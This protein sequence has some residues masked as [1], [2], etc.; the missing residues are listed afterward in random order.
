MIAWR[1]ECNLQCFFVS[2]FPGRRGQSF[3]ITALRNW[4]SPL[5]AERLCIPPIKSS[6]RAGWVRGRPSGDWGR[7][8]GPPPANGDTRLHPPD[9]QRLV[10]TLSHPSSASLIQVWRGNRNRR[11]LHAGLAQTY[12]GAT[13]FVSMVP[14]KQ[15]EGIRDRLRGRLSRLR[16]KSRDASDHARVQD[17]NSSSPKVPKSADPTAK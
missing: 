6:A 10:S 4:K 13:S 9:S 7:G 17:T 15:N 1:Y 14:A 16:G 11:S 2:V 8:A 12:Q 5:F 3:V